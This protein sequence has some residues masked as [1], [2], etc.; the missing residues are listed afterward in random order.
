MPNLKTSNYPI[1]ACIIFLFTSLTAYSSLAKTDKSIVHN[2]IKML[3]VGDRARVNVT[4]YDE[5]GID[6]V[7]IYFKHQSGASYVYVSLTATNIKNYSGLLPTPSVAN[8]T[9]DYL[10]L[11]KNALGEVY[12]SQTYTV[13]ILPGKAALNTVPIAVFTDLA[14]APSKIDGFSDNLT[15]DITE[16]GAKYGIIAELYGSSSA[17]TA[18][19]GTGLSN[20]GSVTATT[21]TTNIAAAGVSAGSS[22]KTAS[23][24]AVA[25]GG[26]S[27]TAVVG[28]L[29]LVGGA[30][31]AAS[32][33]GGD[34]PGGNE[35]GP[36]PV[37]PQ[38]PDYNGTYTVDLDG[39]LTDNVAGD[40]SSSAQ[41]RFSNVN[42]TVSGGSI[43]LDFDSGTMTG[44]ISDADFNIM[45]GSLD[46]LMGT[47]GFASTDAIT[48]QTFD[49]SFSSETEF[50]SD[51]FTMVTSEF[52]VDECAYNASITGSR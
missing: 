39:T 11:V 13:D 34:E 15:L 20:A 47:S 42:L 25:T 3:S 29:A 43:T 30:V 2:P 51:T 38:P 48:W 45:T 52:G 31:A 16:S 6:V 17:G 12:K 18:T 27:T 4:V 14:E 44:S 22:T 50:S 26:L 10:V 7:R 8:S 32:G 9:F 28:G 1:A 24:A 19:V 36:Q 35:P 37:V 21:S 40:C 33:G 49:A 5:S 46:V 23:T 41:V